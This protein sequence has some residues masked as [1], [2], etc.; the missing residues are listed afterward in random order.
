[1]I[2]GSGITIGAVMIYGRDLSGAEMAAN[3]T[4][5]RSQYGV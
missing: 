5:L 1:M 2:I 3:F 4:A